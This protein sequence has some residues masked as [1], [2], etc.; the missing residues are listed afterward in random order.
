MQVFLLLNTLTFR[1]RLLQL[2][3]E[4]VVDHVCSCSVRVIVVLCLDD[5]MLLAC[6]PHRLLGLRGGRWDLVVGLGLMLLVG[7]AE[8]ATETVL[9]RR[10]SLLLNDI[11]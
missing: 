10:S 7:A 8:P 3:V 11:G 9:H 5:S 2:G 4:L 1:L 6:A